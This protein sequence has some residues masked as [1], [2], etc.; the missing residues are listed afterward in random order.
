[1]IFLTIIRLKLRTRTCNEKM[2]LEFEYLLIY[3]TTINMYIVYYILNRKLYNIFI[4]IYIDFHFQL[5]YNTY[6][7]ATVV[8][9]TIINHT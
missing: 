8:L 3:T 9:K 5:N 4:Y 7:K 2:C 1:L 6:F